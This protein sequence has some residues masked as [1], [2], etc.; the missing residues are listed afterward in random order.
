M[1]RTPENG[2]RIVLR[3]IVARISAMRASAWRWPADAASNSARET[4]SCC[5]SPCIRSK[6]T[7]ASSSCDSAPA[8]C[9]CS[10][11][12]S[13]CTRMSP[14]CTALPESNAMRATTPGRSALTV[15]PCTAAMVPIAFS[16]DGHSSCA[17]TIVVTASGGGCIAANS[18]AIAWN[19]LNFKKPRPLMNVI[20]K[21][22]IRIIRLAI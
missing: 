11:R 14:F 20:I 2:A 9:A 22:T 21:T 7:R 17:A 13:S 19:C 10:W 18:P 15:T 5:T 6:L 12:V 1:P 8:N 4:A 3:S 16:V